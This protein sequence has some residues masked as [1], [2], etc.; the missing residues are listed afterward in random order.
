[1]IIPPFGSALISVGVMES[2]PRAVATGSNLLARSGSRI[3]VA[4][5]LP[6]SVLTSSPNRALHPFFPLEIIERES[7]LFILTGNIHALRG[8]FKNLSND[9]SA[10]C[11]LVPRYDISSVTLTKGRSIVRPFSKPLRIRGQMYALRQT[12]GVLP[13]ASAV[14]LIAATNRRLL[15]C[16]FP[17]SAD[18]MRAK[19]QAQIRVA[20]QVRKSLALK[21]PP[22][23]S[24]I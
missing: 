7:A 6:L 10:G 17:F 5:S 3:M 23:T 9:R 15:A 1:M 14:S 12:A 13:R 20:A 22:I 8:C 21:F 24:L 16:W 2:V 19:A 4:R 11:R 18:C